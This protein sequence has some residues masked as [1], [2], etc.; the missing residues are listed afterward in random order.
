[1]MAVEQLL[2]HLKRNGIRVTLKQ[3]KLQ[4]HAGKG[5]FTEELKLQLKENKEGIIAYLSKNN[6]DNKRPITTRQI[7][8]EPPLSFA[9]Q[10]LWFI[11]QLQGGTPE[12]NM[13]MVFD[14][15]GPLNLS[16]VT[17]VFSQIIARHEVLRT[18]YVETE[19]E[20]KQ[21][22]RSLSDI[23]F[24]INEIDQR[25][26][27][28]ETQSEAVNAYVEG[29]ILK[30]FNLAQDLMLRVSY[31]HTGDETGVLV[32]N[33]HHIATDGWSMEVLI[34]EFFALYE[35]FSQGKPNSLPELDIQY[36]DYAHWQ[37]NQLEGEVLDTQLD[38]WAKQLDEV[39]P[40][41]SLPLSYPRPEVR[42]HVSAI[43]RS[44]LSADISQKLQ[45]IAKQH[46]LTPFML[47]HG[48]LSLLLSRH[49]NSSDIVI[50]T[51]VANRKQEELAPLIGLFANTLV[52]RANTQHA[53]L[54]EYFSHIRQVHLGAQ[55]NQDVPFEQLVER[56]NIPRSTAHTPLFQIILTTN[57]NYRLNDDTNLDAM[58]LSGV[59]LSPYQ[60]DRVQAK[61]D[62][63]IDMSISDEGVGISWTYIFFRYISW[64]GNDIPRTQT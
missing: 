63:D 48:A 32:F 21:V 36:A 40:I 49:S 25:H 44:N 28:R 41:H 42:K 35:A 45:A 1:M 61:C 34:K 16:L 18:V 62:L 3:G 30:P 60:S 47:L 9:Q 46:Q 56:L 33:M 52:L 50:G 4:I 26:L 22:I 39:P 14:V 2:L 12:Y 27:T 64:L 17:D 15:Q 53:T 23:D 20:T 6:S 13:P 54:A 37:R 58:T 59:T 7:L 5:Q 51:P 31:I 38:Y 19:G 10:R 11:D 29:D 8:D 24:A 57:T 43:V 55:S